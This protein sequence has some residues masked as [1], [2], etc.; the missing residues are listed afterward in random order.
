MIRSIV[1]WGVYLGPLILG[2]YHISR[3]QKKSQPLYTD[4]WVAHMME[5]GCSLS[6]KELT[7]GSATGP[8][9]WF[10]VVLGLR[11]QGLRTFPTRK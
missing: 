9:V 3:S 11:V 6:S 2:N 4:A 7:S 8:G 10:R 5:S 1:C